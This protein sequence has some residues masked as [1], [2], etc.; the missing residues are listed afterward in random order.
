MVASL[1]IKKRLL[2]KY[3]CS[4]TSLQRTPPGSQNS[5]H[6]REVSVTYRFFPNRL[7]V[8][9]KTALGYQGIVQSTSRCVKS[10]V[11]GKEK[12]QREYVRGFHVYKTIQKRVASWRVF[13]MR[14]RANQQSGQKCRCLLWFVLIL[15]VKKSWLAMC[16]RNLQDCIHVSIPA[17]L[18][19]GHL[20]N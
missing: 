6:F 9:Q 11:L 10:L 16:K 15:T 12:A 5:G 13:V 4:E 2:G 20:C 19:F 1:D 14:E 7:T 3:A 8:L 18:R 17:L